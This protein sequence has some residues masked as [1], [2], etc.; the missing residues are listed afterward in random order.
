[1]HRRPAPLPPPETPTFFGVAYT[2]RLFREIDASNALGKLRKATGGHPDPRNCDHARALLEWLNNWGCMIATERFPAISKCLATWFRRHEQQFPRCEIYDLQ[3]PQLDVLADAYKGLLA[4][5]G[6]GP[7]AASK[8]L[9]VLCQDAA[10]PWDDAIRKKLLLG[11]APGQYRKMLVYSGREAAAL[12]ADA[13]RCGVSDH[14]AIP[15]AVN[16]QAIT[17][18]ELLDEY[19]WVTI[20]RR[21]TIPSGEELRQWVGWTGR[22]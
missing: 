16:S 20:T 3:A 5:R 11:N 13:A 9:F 8:A 6:F 12:I 19:H 4:I 10:I 17:L 22:E 18:P 21:H 15:S 14:R 2:S 7:T 1:M